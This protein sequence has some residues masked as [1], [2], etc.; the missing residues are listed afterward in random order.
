MNQI[1]C[2]EQNRYFTYNVFI[3][4]IARNPKAIFLEMILIDV[5]IGRGYFLLSIYFA[6]L[7]ID[8]IKD[9]KP[10]FTKTRLGVIH[11]V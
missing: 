11:E 10:T 1:H 5:S 6:Y 9:K 8:I 3:F 7:A 2:Y 4:C